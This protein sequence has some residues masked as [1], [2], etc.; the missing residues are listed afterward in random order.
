MVPCSFRIFLRLVFMRLN[1][2]TVVLAIALLTGSTPAFAQDVREAVVRALE[3]NPAIAGAYDRQEAAE[4]NKDAEASNYYPEISTALTAGR[5]YQDNSTSRGLSV[6]RGA[7]YSGYGEANIALRQMIFDGLETQNRV[8]AADARLESKGYDLME[9][10]E[11]ITFDIVRNYIEIMRLRSALDLLSVQL[12]SI[13]DYKARIINMVKE[14]VAD[15]AEL[16]QARDVSMVVNS[17]IADYEGRLASARAAY[18]EATGEAPPAQLVMPASVTS[19]I[20]DN[21]VDAV[22]A[23]K[24]RN[25]M[26]MSV[27]MASNATRHDMKAEQGK[28]YPDVTGELSYYKNDKKDIIGGENKDARAVVKMNWAFSTGGREFSEFRKKQSEHDAALR[29]AEEA[30]RQVERAIYES[31]AKY[32]TF[33]RKL[34]LSKDRVDLNEK[35]VS[36]YESQ[37]EGSRISLLSL[38]RAQSQLF[39]AKLDRSDNRFN[40]LASEYGVLASL[41][42]LKNAI[43]SMPED[44]RTRPVTEGEDNRQ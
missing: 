6:E 35:L 7:A 16:Q 14:G 25:P 28:M 3:R 42:M 13:D 23:A 2:K 39:K 20:N 11:E 19:Q 1:I 15:E 44:V 29:K 8:G 26:L 22:A 37:F 30:E 32:R 38:M 10:E 4:H 9:V 43:L 17:I 36:A 24:L 40:L 31:Y 5:V 12:R 27:R 18:Y 34:Q 41:S 33:Q 21:I